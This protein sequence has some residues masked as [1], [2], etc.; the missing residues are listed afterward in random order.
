MFGVGSIGILVFPIFLIP[1]NYWVG[2]KIL[3]SGNFIFNF[4]MLLN[5]IFVF[6]FFVLFINFIE[7]YVF[8]GYVLKRNLIYLL[9]SGFFEASVTTLIL[10]LL[11]KGRMKYG[12]KRYI[13][14]LALMP[15]VI[16]MFAVWIISGSFFE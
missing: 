12:V 1:F 10:L 4:I 16:L 3:K 9:L 11:L 14:L 2:K 5:L 7:E 13:Y 8:S 6:H 15:S